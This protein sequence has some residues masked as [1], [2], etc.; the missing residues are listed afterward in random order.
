MI[1]KLN[2]SVCVKE[3]EAILKKKKHKKNPDQG[4][5]KPTCLK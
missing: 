5:S 2:S 1:K 3:I 4:I